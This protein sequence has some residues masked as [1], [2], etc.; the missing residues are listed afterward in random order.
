MTFTRT[1][2]LSLLALVAALPAAEKNKQRL[3]DAVMVME[4][5]MGIADRSIPQSLLDKAQCVTVIPGLKKGA[6][7]IGARYGK[8]YITCRRAGGAGWSAPA[9]VR[10]EG[11]S[12]GLQAGASETDIVMLVMNESGARKL[13][14]SKF[15][16]GAGV[17]AAAGPV[18]RTAN[19]ETDAQLRAEILTY[20]RS[21]G[22]FAGAALQGGTL[23]PDL[24][25]NKAMYGS[26]LITKEI[27]EDPK[28]EP[29]KAGAD[30]IAVL[31][32]YSSRK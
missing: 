20:S 16:L 25:A 6:F 11:G 3:E 28:I 21:R 29:T 27:V 15:T 2:S 5:I 18:G 10:V 17:A 7:I 12:F 30:L 1:V 9:T 14:Q 26:R 4:E 22:L 19:A 13:M 8:G 24:D 23:R 31:N 32:K